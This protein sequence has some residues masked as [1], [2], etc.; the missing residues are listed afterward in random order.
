MRE[1]EGA[2][3]EKMGGQ[4][5]TRHA[6]G[7]AGIETWRAGGRVRTGCGQGGG[8]RGHRG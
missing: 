3:H 7:G 4:Y 1:N 8:G 5:T 6:I 2:T